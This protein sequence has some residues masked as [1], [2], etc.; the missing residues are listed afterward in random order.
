M[1]E[2]Y[3]QLKKHGTDVRTEVV[4]GLTTFLTMPTSSS[5]IR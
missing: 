3:F 4:A 2:T 1:L 5:S